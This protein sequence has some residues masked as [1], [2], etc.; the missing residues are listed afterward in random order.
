MTLSLEVLVFIILKSVRAKAF[1]LIS[2]FSSLIVMSI[3][4]LK[5]QSQLKFSQDICQ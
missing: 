2:L 5:N 3:I 4:A 1:D